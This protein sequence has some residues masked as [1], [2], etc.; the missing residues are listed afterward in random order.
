M[1]T[2]RLTLPAAGP[3]PAMP[4]C[5]RCCTASRRDSSCSQISGERSGEFR[6]S[7]A[8]TRGTPP[9]PGSG[10]G[11]PSRPAG[12]NRP[13]EIGAE[14]DE[15]DVCEFHVVLPLSWIVRILPG[16]DPPESA[17]P[18]IIRFNTSPNGISRIRP[19]DRSSGKRRRSASARQAPGHLS[20]FARGRGSG[21][22]HDN[23]PYARGG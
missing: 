4:V 8:R 1:K 22:T 16:G 11:G 23:C 13:A 15:R 10:G 3:P 14:G 17:C 12:G 18:P 9:C 6:S 20:F 21:R 7:S 2:E 5:R 19:S